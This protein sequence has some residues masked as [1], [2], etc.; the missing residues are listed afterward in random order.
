LKTKLL[1]NKDKFMIKN[2]DLVFSFN[3]LAT[4]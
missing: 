1:I 4:Q 2:A 3:G